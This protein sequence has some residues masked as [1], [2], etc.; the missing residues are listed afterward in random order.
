MAKVLA[1]GLQ[2]SRG[3]TEGLL[4]GNA[5]SSSYS[6]KALG[7]RASPLFQEGLEQSGRAEQFSAPQTESHPSSPTAFE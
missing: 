7:Q 3:Q 1:H 2:Q 5:L 4:Q 6:R